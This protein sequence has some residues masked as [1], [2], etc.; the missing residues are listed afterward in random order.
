MTKIDNDLNDGICKKIGL[1]D[2]TLKQSLKMNVGMLQLK[3]T[4]K[5]CFCDNLSNQTKAVV[6][7]SSAW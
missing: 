3:T 7:S 4:G 2:R 6:V 5:R 1:I